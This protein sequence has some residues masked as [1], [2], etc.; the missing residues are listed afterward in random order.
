MYSAGNKNLSLRAIVSGG[1]RSEP[2]RCRG[3]NGWVTKGNNRALGF[4][5]L[6]L[7]VVIAILGMVAA[8][9]LPALKGIGRTAAINAA[10][11]QVLDD[12]AAARQAAISGRSEVYLVFVPPLSQWVNQAGPLTEPA[13]WALLTVQDR[14]IAT[15]LLAGQYTAYALFAARQVGD[16]PGQSHPRY[17]T[18]WRTLPNG[19]FFATNQFGLGSSL[20]TTVRIQAEGQAIRVQQFAR[21]LFPFPSASSPVT[22]WLPCI[23]FDSSGRLIN[24]RDD[25]SEYESIALA[26]GSVM[27]MRDQNGQLRCADVDVLETPPGNWTNAFNVVLIDWLTGRGRLEQKRVK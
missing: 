9:T 2:F 23:G 13:N 4:T 3:A 14:R 18:P 24:L 27:A 8:I 17:L 22:I 11:R 10:T 25:F 20:L 15:N 16:Q 5:L 12:V 19:T 21:R 26:Q 6:E 7:L 1:G